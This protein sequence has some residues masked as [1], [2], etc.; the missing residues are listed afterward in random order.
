MFSKTAIR[1]VMSCLAAAS[2]FVGLAHAQ[3]I[4][5]VINAGTYGAYPP[6]EF[7]DTETG[8]LVGFA[9]ELFEAMAKKVGA[10]VNWQVFSFPDLTSFAPLKT[11]RVDIYGGGAMSDLP[12]RR[13]SGVSF[14]DYVYEPN[15]LYTSKANAT[16]FKAI[17]DLCG[18]KIG[19]T[20][21]STPAFPLLEKISKET[22]DK[23]GKP[24]FIVEGIES[25]NI[26]KL[27]LKQGR[28]D[29]GVAGAA[30]LAREGDEWVLIGKPL[31]KAMYGMAFMNDRKEMGEALTKALD[32][33]IADGTYEKLLKKW[34]LPVQDSH[35]GKA[36]L[37]QGTELK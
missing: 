31:A 7:K 12:A 1:L 30:M 33:L 22:C 3:G 36:G 26:A 9:P 29:A 27:Q 10:T 4:P 32:E 2:L 25:Q 16:Q 14:I 15:F 19:P 18:K 11:G 23:E 6:F 20:R 5:K 21:A 24:P 34:N 37:N 35:I 17:V 8:K 28:L 13:E